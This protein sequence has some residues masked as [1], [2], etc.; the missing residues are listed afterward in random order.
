MVYTSKVSIV[1]LNWNGGK[2]LKE[3]LDSVLK[4]DYQDLEII[5][6][7]N[8][9]T[10]GSQELVKKCYPQVILIENERNLGFCVG[11]NI[12]IKRATSNIIILLNNDTIVDRSWVKEILK[13]AQDPR[14]G[15]VGCRLYFP[16]TKIIQS[17]GYRMKF[18]GFWESIGAGQ[19]DKG[20]FDKVGCVDYVSGAALAVKREVLDKIGLLDPA[21]YAYCEDVDLCY[22]AR[23]AG[24]KVVT[25]N[26]IVY[27]YGSLSWDRLPVRKMYLVQRNRIYFILKH[28]SP[29]TLLRY[30][31]EYPVMSFMVNLCRFIRGETGLQKTATL[32]KIQIRGK[33]PVVAFTKEIS[34]LVMFFITLLL[35]VVKTWLRGKRRAL[36]VFK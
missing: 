15:I 4:T 27:H 36:E 5:V 30:V 18:L 25:S 1:I 34:R 32:N 3:C 14:V 24:Y 23:R 17:L 6:V 12:G 8:A 20:Q 11:N 9:S 22:R 16:G 10:D 33:I 26:A 13:C 29:K 21:F 31:V 19:E 35:L 2:Y 28:Y 7:D